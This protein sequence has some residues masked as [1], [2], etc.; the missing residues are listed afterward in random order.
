MNTFIGFF[1]NS[2]AKAVLKHVHLS[3][4]HFPHFLRVYAGDRRLRGVEVRGHDISLWALP[5]GQRQDSQGW[6]DESKRPSL[7][8]WQPGVDRTQMQ[9]HHICAILNKF[10]FLKSEGEH[11]NMAVDEAFRQP[12]PNGGLKH[13][14]NSRHEED[15]GDELALGC[16]VVLNAQ[17]LGED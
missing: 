4:A 7:Q 2:L 8:D 5:L 3:H 1:F 6:C 16:I 12:G 15:G 11:G 10:L 17:R 13:G 14:R 9:F